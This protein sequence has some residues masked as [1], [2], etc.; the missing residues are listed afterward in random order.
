MDVLIFLGGTAAFI[1]S[2]IGL[3]QGEANYIFFE[4]SATIFTL[5]LLGNWFEKRAVKQTTTAIEELT[6]L[7]TQSARRILP[8]GTVVSL[9]P[10]EIR[11]GYLLQVNEGDQVP[12]DGILVQGEILVDESML[13]GESDPTRKKEGAEV[14]GG[15]LVLEGNF[16]LKVTSTGKDSFLGQ[17]IELVKSAQRDKPVI[18][19]LADRISAIFVPVVLGISLL[20]LFI[21]HF[22][23]G[24]SFP[25]SLMRAHSRTGH[26]LSLCDGLGY[27]HGGYGGYRPFSA[28][29][30]S[31]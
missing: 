12:A 31:D 2:L 15:A 17:M 14:V 11:P 13:T 10:N 16:R 30:N 24:V 5:V 4:T 20:T 9:Q 18:Q 7:Q 3:A 23:F 26:F 28:D 19:R 25:D 27:T 22:G 1:Y 21:N 29:W 6:R 8:S